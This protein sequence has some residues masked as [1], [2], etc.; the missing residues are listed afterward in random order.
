MPKVTYNKCNKIKWNHF[1]LISLEV[2]FFFLSCRIC[3]FCHMMH[4]RIISPISRGEVF[5]VGIEMKNYTN[6]IKWAGFTE[7]WL[8]IPKIN[9]F[10]SQKPHQCVLLWIMNVSACLQY[11]FVKREKKKK[12][13]QSDCKAEQ[14]SGPVPHPPLPP[15]P[16]PPP[17]RY[18][19]LIKA[20]VGGIFLSVLP[21]SRFAP[22]QP[23]RPHWPGCNVTQ[24]G[25]HSP[26]TPGNYT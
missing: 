5:Q 9:A 1:C 15:P 26:A 3:T 8:F 19:Q 17:P 18:T 22:R 14:S 20:P 24:P 13:L 12:V 6:D 10:M 11:S 7:M 4:L 25:F 21:E 16:P 23:A 2:L